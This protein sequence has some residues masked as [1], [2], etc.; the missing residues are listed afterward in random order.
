MKPITTIL[1][2]ITFATGYSQDIDCSKF[3]TGYFQNIDSKDGNT[4]IKR[5][6]KYQ[7]E[8]DVATGVKIKLKVVWLNEC[9]YKLTLIKGN[10]KWKKEKQ[11]PNNPDLIVKITSVGDDYYTQVAHFVGI[12]DFTYTSRIKRVKK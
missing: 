7:Y 10:A 6:K 3:K 2:L 9:T 8:T 4:F 1:L 11:I 5:T 12:E